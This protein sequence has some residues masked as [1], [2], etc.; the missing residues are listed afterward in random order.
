MPAI[1]SKKDSKMLAGIILLLFN[2]QND[3]MI[4]YHLYFKRREINLD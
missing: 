1:H 2:P 3:L 4:Y